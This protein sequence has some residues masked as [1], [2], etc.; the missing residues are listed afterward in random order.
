[1]QT[2]TERN[3]QR[4]RF[5]GRPTQKDSGRAREGDRDGSGKRGEGAPI[6]NLWLTIVMGAP[7]PWSPVYAYS[8]QLSSDNAAAT[9]LTKD[10]LPAPEM[11]LI[12]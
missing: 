6:Y 2:E 9:P 12:N 5:R 10:D 11:M 8:C 7:L 3:T 1:M 4:K